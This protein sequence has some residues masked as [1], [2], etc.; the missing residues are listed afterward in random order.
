MPTGITSK[1]FTFQCCVLM[2]IPNILYVI[3]SSLQLQ[4]FADNM[5]RNDQR[6]LLRA[7]IQSEILACVVSLKSQNCRVSG[8]AI[9]KKNRPRQ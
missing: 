9:V 3:G 4:L 5:N 8:V 6:Y 1:T 2:M 7:D